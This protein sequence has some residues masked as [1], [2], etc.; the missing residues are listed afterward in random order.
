MTYPTNTVSLLAPSVALLRGVSAAAAMAMCSPAHATVMDDCD[1]NDAPSWYVVGGCANLQPC[2]WSVSLV[3]GV[4]TL[5]CDLTSTGGPQTGANY[6]GVTMYPGSDNDF[7]FWGTLSAGQRF[8]CVADAV[9]TPSIDTIKVQVVGS[10]EDDTMRWRYGATTTELKQSL[11][12]AAYSNIDIVTGEM[13]GG[14]G[15]DTIVGPTSS[16]SLDTPVYYGGDGDDDM[17]LGGIKPDAYGQK[18]ND[19]IDSRS[20]SGSAHVEGGGVGSND[21]NGDDIILIDTGTVKGQF[22]DD[23]ICDYGGGATIQG[24]PGTDTIWGGPS[25]WDLVEG[26]GGTDTCG[27]ADPSDIN[28][29]CENTITSIP[30]ACP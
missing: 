27:A 13:S 30:P 26:G 4:Q 9:T 22:G 7:S 15:E 14:G 11:I 17:L 19:L 21:T 2:N 18:G 28:H 1:S 29:D 23:L 16:N 10:D 20:S 8:C 3:D 5:S 6:W 12:T 24:G 25:G